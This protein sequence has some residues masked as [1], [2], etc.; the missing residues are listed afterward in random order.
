MNV[1]GLA[2]AVIS[3]PLL[4]PVLYAAAFVTATVLVRWVPRISKTTAFVTATRLTPIDGLR[5]FLGLGVFIHH[6]AMT[7][8]FI[9]GQPWQVPP[10]RIVVHLGETGVS[11]FFMITSFLFWSRVVARGANMS[12][13]EFFVARLYRLY[14]GYLLALGLMVAAVLWTTAQRSPFTV[15]PLFGPLLDWRG[16]TMFL[17][18]DLGHFADTQII[19]AKVVWS[20]RYEWLFYIALPL[21]AFLFSRARSIAALSGSLGA[22][23]IDLVFLC[24][25]LGQRSLGRASLAGR[26][27][28]G[29]RDLFSLST[30]RPIALAGFPEDDAPQSGNRS[31]NILGGCPR[32]FSSAGCRR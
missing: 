20:L 24:D 13:S 31:A 30:A 12:W 11:L 10:S 2:E 15:S 32:G 5:A 19:V 8:F 14:P 4:A 29:R 23:L 25:C 7:W 26:S 21:L 1:T 6:T 17:T 22:L 27:V 18:P 3:G 28:A 9:N 16:F